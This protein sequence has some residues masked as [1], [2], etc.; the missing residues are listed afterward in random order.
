M[1]PAGW[2]LR[3]ADNTCVQT[4]AASGAGCGARR[5]CDA[6]AGVCVCQAGYTGAACDTCAEGFQDNDRNGSCTPSCAMTTCPGAQLCSDTMGTARCA[7]P[8]NKTGANCDQCP[9]G[10]VVRPSDGACVQTCTSV[11]PTCGARRTCDDSSGTPTCVCQPGFAGDTCTACAAGYTSDGAGQCVRSA[12][13]GTTLLGAGRFQGADYLLAIDPVAGTATALRPVPGLGSL[14]FTTDPQSKA[15]YTSNGSAIHRLDPTTGRSTLVATATSTSGLAFL[16]GALYT[17]GTLS[18][19]LLKRIDLA[20]AGVA[21]VG[22]TQVSAV[23]AM[24]VDP[25]G[26][27][28]VATPPVAPRNNGAELLRVD[29]ATGMTQKA[30]A[31]EVEGERLR[32]GDPRSALAFDATGKLF[33]VLRLGRTPE[34][35]LADYC[36]RLASGLGY[37]GYD[38]APLTSVTIEYNGVGPGATRPLGARGTMGKEIVAYLSYGRRT[39]AKGTLRVET[40]NPEA[41]LCVST[42]EEVLEL[43]LPVAEARFAGIGLSGHQPTFSLVVDGSVPPVTAP[44]LHV[45]PNRGTA[46]PAFSAYQLSKVYT[47]AEWQQR[48][49]TPTVSAWDTDTTAPALLVEVDPTTLVLKRSI[50]LP[51]VELFPLLAPFTP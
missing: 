30:G 14:R 15:I 38:R 49:L 5:T 41:F 34:Q 25:A 29:A 51:G 36:R 6:A 24:A 7:C 10:W 39:A 13:P 44:S 2:V 22:P 17:V 21:D 40:T 3:Q 27:L 31:L 8:G 48:G 1:C 32:P 33:M 43:H 19:F 35:L 23:Q 45:H 47:A 26:A 20:T 50:G 18:P 42:Y 28:L 46:A 11:G 9:T 37:A 16:G 12:P 4:C